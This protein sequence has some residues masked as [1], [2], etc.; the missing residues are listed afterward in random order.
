M[1]VDMRIV[2]LKSIPKTAFGLTTRRSKWYRWKKPTRVWLTIGS[3][4]LALPT[5]RE[6]SNYC[7]GS[8]LEKIEL[9][10]AFAAFLKCLNGQQVE[11]LLI[12]GYAVNLHGYIRTTDDM[13]VWIA[14]NQTN[15]QKIVRALDAYGFDVDGLD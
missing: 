5:A 14:I 1:L 7:G 3:H 11:Y 2:W 12:G 8:L 4:G 6:H 9:S 13:H 15:P 10:P